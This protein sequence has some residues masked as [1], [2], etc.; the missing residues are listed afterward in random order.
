M[1]L[2]YVEIDNCPQRLVVLEQGQDIR[3]DDIGQVW[4]FCESNIGIV[5]TQNA[6]D[7]KASLAD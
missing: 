5:F 3:W 1:E 7:V 2:P 6:I 4:L